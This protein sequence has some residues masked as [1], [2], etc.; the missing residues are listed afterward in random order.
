MELSPLTGTDPDFRPLLV[1]GDERVLAAEVARWSELG[2]AVR[3]VRGRKM[4]TLP[5]LYDEFAAALQFPL[6]FGENKDAFEECLADLDGLSCGEG[7]VIVLVEPDEFLA[8]TDASDFHWF[9]EVLGAVTSELAK[10]IDLGE[11]WDRP[12]VPFHVV[13]AATEAQPGDAVTR[14]AAAGREP[15]AYALA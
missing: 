1:T 4:R 5:G 8:D 3:V 6:Y 7:L 12:P 11:A 9:V 10:P 13:L 15:E 14:W 2:L